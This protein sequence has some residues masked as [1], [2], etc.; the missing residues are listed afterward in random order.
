MRTLRRMTVSLVPPAERCS[1]ETSPH[2]MRRCCP[3]IHAG[4][5]EAEAAKSG[6]TTQLRAKLR[7]PPPQKRASLQTAQDPEV[8][9]DPKFDEDADGEPGPAG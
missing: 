2:L 3:H 1:N 9:E 6:V 4:A 8:D 7:V 5:P